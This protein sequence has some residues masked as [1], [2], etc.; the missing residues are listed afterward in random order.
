VPQRRGHRHRQQDV[1][2]QRH[3]HCRQRGVMRVAADNDAAGLS[4]RVSFGHNGVALCARCR[5]LAG[6][7]VGMCA[8]DTR[9]HHTA[10][11]C[12]CCSERQQLARAAGRVGE[13]P[14]LHRPLCTHVTNHGYMRRQRGPHALARLERACSAAGAAHCVR[15]ADCRLLPLPPCSCLCCACMQ[16]A[17]R[18]HSAMCH[19]HHTPPRTAPCRG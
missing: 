3:H 12:V 2:A 14:L 7:H 19:A 10:H 1:R 17:V 6:G 18:N 16:H 5:L 15:C 4:G 9:T 11:T 8:A 13:P